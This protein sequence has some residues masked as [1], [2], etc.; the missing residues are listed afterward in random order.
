[1]LEQVEQPRLIELES[2]KLKD[3]YYL[4][5]E[6]LTEFTIRMP[7][8]NVKTNEIAVLKVKNAKDI[9]AVK[10]GL[11]KHAIDVQKQFETY[12]QDQYENAKNYKIVTKGNYVLFVISESAD[13]LVK[14]FSDIF[15]KK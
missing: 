15:E 5:P 4:D 1:M 3:I 9:A 12:L 13:D 10:K 8:M 6:L 2:D 7:L 11:E 14:A